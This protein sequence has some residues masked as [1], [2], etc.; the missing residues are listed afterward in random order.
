MKSIG[1]PERYN[2][3]FHGKEFTPTTGGA[4]LQRLLDSSVRTDRFSL[5]I[6]LVAILRVHNPFS[7]DRKETARGGLLFNIVMD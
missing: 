7:R 2:A 5:I 1:I 4:I 3:L 6:F